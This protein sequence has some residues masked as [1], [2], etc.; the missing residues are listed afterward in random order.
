MSEPQH[1][2]TPTERLHDLAMAA[3]TKTAPTT[4]TKTPSVG[5]APSGPMAGQWICKDI[6]GDPLHDGETQLDGWSRTL[7]L[8]RTVQRDLIELNAEVLTRALEA[9]LEKRKS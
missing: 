3:I 6:G 2:L 9:T 1:K 5:M 8:A 4:A 7:D